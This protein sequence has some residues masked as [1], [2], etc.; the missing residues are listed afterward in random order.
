MSSKPTI[1]NPFDQAIAEIPS[2]AL[3][4]SG[5]REQRARYASL[6][7]RVTRLQREPEAVLIE[8]CEALDQETLDHALAVE[9]E[10]C[11]FFQFELDERKRQLTVTVREAEQAPALD[12]IAAHLTEARQDG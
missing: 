5:L 2:C 7:S 12:A 9:R 11:P 6:A 3:G 1:T 8:F 10:C 4:E